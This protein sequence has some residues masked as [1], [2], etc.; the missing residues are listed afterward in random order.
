MNVSSGADTEYWVVDVSK[1]DLA[2][3]SGNLISLADPSMGPS[4]EEV[5]ELLL[6]LGLKCC[7][8]NCTTRP[9]MID[10]VR[11]LEEMWL[12]VRGSELGAH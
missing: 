1:V 6:R 8:E 12:R 11:E 2:N 3:R 9:S 10:V 4:P 5:L 7:N